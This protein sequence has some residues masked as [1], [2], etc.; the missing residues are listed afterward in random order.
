MIVSE[1]GAREPTLFRVTITHA[2]A[3]AA[4]ALDSAQYS[5]NVRRATP[6][7]VGENVDTELLFAGLDKTD[8]S[9]HTL[10]LECTG[11]FG[12]DGGITMQTSQGNELQ[13]K[14]EKG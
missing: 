13:D 14:S 6:L 5:I 8:I 2:L 1:I 3:A 11:K 4:S 7:L 10:I 12:R 9:Q